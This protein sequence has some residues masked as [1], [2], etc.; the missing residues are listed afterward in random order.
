[1]RSILGAQS[2]HVF[3]CSWFWCFWCCHILYNWV[4]LI[5]VDQEV[6]AEV[7]V[8]IVEVCGGGRRHVAGIGNFGF[9]FG[10]AWAFCLAKMGQ[11]KQ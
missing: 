6:G 8:V 4:A 5:I 1:M 3:F 10:D 11:A 2:V 7:I 9:G